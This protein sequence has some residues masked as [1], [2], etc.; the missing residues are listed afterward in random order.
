MEEI[1]LE[2][3]DFECYLV[4]NLGR[5]KKIF[6][7]KE[8]I[9]KPKIRGKYLAVN[10][11]FEGNK[12]TKSIHRLVAETFLENIN[13]YSCVNHK[14]ENK[15]NNFLE[16]LEWCTHK[17]NLNYGN[18]KN[19]ISEKMKKDFKYYEEKPVRRNSFLKKCEKENIDFNSFEEIYSGEKDGTNKK[20]FYFLLI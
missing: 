17:E 12:K 2:I 20:Y 7:T 1:F 9:L 5:V 10:L 14:D 8:K 16:N 3:K 4:S 11:T 19:K 6:K 18:C 15:T 13:N